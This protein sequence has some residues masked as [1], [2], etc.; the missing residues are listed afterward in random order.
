MSITIYFYRYTGLN[1]FKPGFDDYNRVTYSIRIGWCGIQFCTGKRI[2]E[3][4][5]DKWFS[6]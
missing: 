5:F 3:A 1:W 4:Q 2:T 6:A